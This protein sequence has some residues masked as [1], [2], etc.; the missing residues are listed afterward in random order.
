MEK[1]VY[2]DSGFSNQRINF[3]DTASTTEGVLRFAHGTIVLKKIHFPQLKA[4]KNIFAD[5]RSVHRGM[6]MTE[7]ARYL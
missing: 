1:Q 3:S 4:A 7:R 2:H 5:L 6:L